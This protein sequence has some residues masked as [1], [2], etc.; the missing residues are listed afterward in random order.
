[1]I[2]FDAAT[3]TYPE[4]T[5]PVLADVDLSIDEG[6]MCL[7]IGR[8][9]SGK[10]TLL[11]CINGLVPHFSGGRLTGSVTVAGRDTRE[12]RPRDLADVVGFVGQDPLSGFVTDSV[13]DE[14][15]YGMESLGVSP[16]V[17]RKRV[18][19]TLDLL[20]LAEVR[21]RP[22]L[23]LSAGQQQRVAIGSVLTVHPKVLVL[24]EPT[25]ALDPAAAEDVWAALTR[26]VHDLSLTVVLAEHRLERV[27][28]YADRVVFVPGQGLPVES[29]PPA[30]LLAHSPVAPPVVELGRLL[31][32]SPLPLSVRDARRAAGPLREQLASLRPT[33]NK[34]A[35]RL[36]RAAQLR[37]IVSSYGDVLALRGVDLDLRRGEVVALMGRNGAGKSTL[38]SVLAGLRAPKAGVV[39][40]DGAGT[41]G[42][43]RIGLVPHEPTDLLWAQS[44]AAECAEA[45]R[46]ARVPAG[47]TRDLLSTLTADVDDDLHPRDLSE[48]QRLALALAVVLVTDPAVIALDE[49]TRGLDYPAKQQLVQNLRRLADAGRGV[50]LATHDVELAAELA[51][52]IVVLADGE[53]VADGPATE[54]VVAS[55]I[56]APQ[57]SKVLAPLPWLTVRSVEESLAG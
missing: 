51:D 57:V 10:S 16:S 11:R 25:S 47:T 33:V 40:I 32:W 29:G 12:C 23:S 49:P 3:V 35:Q 30:E 20:G 46:G 15:A 18:E 4:A 43:R 19:E 22:L 52:R 42:P 56:F 44:V 53:V 26:L 2:R 8:T 5:A 14:L 27:V 24:D 54:V 7:V 1:M 38:L 37:G 17:M 34:T 31:G 45:D 39:S 28:Q 48:G 55:P 9:G 13:E 36:E 41:S 21:D 50:V 6:E